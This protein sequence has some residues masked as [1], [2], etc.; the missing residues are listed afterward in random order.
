MTHYYQGLPIQ[1]VRESVIMPNATGQRYTQSRQKWSANED[2]LIIQLRG[3]NMIWEDI[4]QRLPGRSPVACRL[5]YQNFLE[6]HSKWDEER[7]NELA[8]IYETLKPQMWAKVAKE[9]AIPWRA[10]EAMHWLLGADEMARRAGAVPFSIAAANEIGSNRSS[11]S[12]SRVHHQ[13]QGSMPGDF[14]DPLPETLHNGNSPMPTN[15]WTMASCQGFFPLLPQLPMIQNSAAGQ[16]VPGLSSIQNQ[17]LPRLAG[18]LPGIAELTSCVGP[19]IAPASVPN[20]GFKTEEDED[21]SDSRTVVTVEDTEIQEHFK[22]DECAA[23]ANRAFNEI[24]GFL[25]NATSRM[26]DCIRQAMLIIVRMDT[27]VALVMLRIIGATGS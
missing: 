15:T 4:S 14:R 8:R 10:V 26:L 17:P 27:V 7:K 9:M 3:R 19:Y 22:I 13:P 5:R 20:M 1:T 21:E 24:E 6:K 16:N 12:H 18:M 2:A 25:E 23:S 11:P